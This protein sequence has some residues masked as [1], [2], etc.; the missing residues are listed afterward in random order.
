MKYLMICP[1][2]HVPEWAGYAKNEKGERIYKTPLLCCSLGSGE[3][4]YFCEGDDPPGGATYCKIDGEHGE[5]AA[6]P[7]WQGCPRAV[8]GLV[9]E[10]GPTGPKENSET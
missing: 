4:L 9:T 10:T 8:H 3:M 6:W 2:G 1:M 5:V 7:I